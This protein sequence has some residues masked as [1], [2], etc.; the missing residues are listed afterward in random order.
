[1][2]FDRGFENKNLDKKIKDRF[3]KNPFYRLINKQDT[4]QIT[5]RRGFN[6]PEDV[7]AIKN[8]KNLFNNFYQGN[9]QKYLEDP[10]DDIMLAAMYCDQMTY[11]DLDWDA[12][13]VLRSGKGDYFDTHFLLALFFLEENKCYNSEIIKN[14]KQKVIID[15]IQAQQNDNNFSDLYAER[16]VFLYW[17]NRGED[18]KK[19]WIDTIS[20]NF[21]DDQF[22]WKN[23]S[24][25]RINAHT[26]GLALLA[27]QYFINTK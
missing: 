22:G 3:L 25:E 13:H 7:N 23:S 15:I 19:E 1:V 20:N 5:I 2:E 8:K 16:I 21:H 27:L 14:A 18:I 9:F 17:A 4:R 6:S 12:L 10:W 24:H 11:N 26:T